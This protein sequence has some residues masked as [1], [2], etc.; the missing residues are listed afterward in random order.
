MRVLL[1]SAA[2]VVFGLIAQASTAS[3][4]SFTATSYSP[5]GHSLWI[6]DGLGGGYGS[7]FHFDP[8][9]VFTTNGVDSASLTGRVVSE[10]RPQGGFDLSFRYND[11]F[12]PYTPAYKRE[13]GAAVAGSDTYFLNLAGGIL[14]GFGQELDGLVL[15]V[16]RRPELSTS[17]ARY[18]TQVGTGSNAKDPND[19]GLANWFYIDVYEFNCLIC[20]N[21]AGGL[22]ED[23]VDAKRGDINIDLAPV[24]LPAGAV[25]L[26]TA[27]AGFG[28]ARTLR[29]S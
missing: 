16:T 6:A 4:T 14:T 2:V 3:T 15:S 19:Y 5:T 1:K 11:D 7:D 20:T 22:F 12:G 26:L 10:N 8:A 18:A 13:G 17:T 23:V 27:L 25:L 21:S 24:P 29:K 28:A 9:G